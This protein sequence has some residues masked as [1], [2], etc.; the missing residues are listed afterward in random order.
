MEERDFSKRNFLRIG[1][2]GETYSQAFSLLHIINK[3]KI[4]RQQQDK[5]TRN[6]NDKVN[7]WNVNDLK[8]RSLNC[9]WLEIL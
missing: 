8:S 2:V 7:T 4:K 3:K 5:V 1:G 6:I 9:K